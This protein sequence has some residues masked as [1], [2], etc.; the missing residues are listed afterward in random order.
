MSA[1]CK[2]QHFAYAVLSNGCCD[3][4][5]VH[6]QTWENQDEGYYAHY[7][8]RALQVAIFKPET[9][10]VPDC[11]KQSCEFVVELASMI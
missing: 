8:L 2:S 3:K 4:Y 1:E 11:Q 7:D 5:D 9:A 10:G 6:K